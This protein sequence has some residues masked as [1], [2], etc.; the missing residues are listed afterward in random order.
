MSDYAKFFRKAR[1]GKDITQTELARLLDFR[2]G[3]LISNIERGISFYPLN[4]LPQV[5]KILDLEIE[6]VL[7]LILRIEEK[8][9]RRI[10]KTKN[11]VGLIKPSKPDL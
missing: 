8:N 5:V 6:P 10:F 1:R 9:L 2:S 4:R 7:S 11:P 3:Q